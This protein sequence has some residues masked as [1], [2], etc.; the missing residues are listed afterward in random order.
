MTNLEDTLSYF[1]REGIKVSNRVTL[2]TGQISFD[3]HAFDN[4]RLTEVHNKALEGQFPEA[5]VTGFGD[6]NVRIGVS[7]IHNAVAWYEKNL[8]VKV[9]EQNDN[10]AHLQVEDAYD[11]M[12]LSQ[13]Y[14]DNI[15]LEQIEGITFENANPSVRNYFDVRPDVFH[16]TYNQLKENGLNPSEV[17]GNPHNGWAGF[18]FFDLDGNRINVWSYPA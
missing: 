5:R 2:P 14:Y 11:W 8:G 16:E 17:A 13:V 3:I 1:E 9:V 10:Y 4:A 7:D 15:W 12:Q 6:V 18:Q